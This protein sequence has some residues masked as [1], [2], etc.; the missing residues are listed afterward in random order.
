MTLSPVKS[1]LNK[2][3]AARAAGS[4]LWEQEGQ[5]AWTWPWRVPAAGTGVATSLPASSRPDPGDGGLSPTKDARTSL[6]H[7]AQQRQS[8]QVTRASPWTQPLDG[9]PGPWG[10]LPWEWG[11]APLFLQLLMSQGGVMVPAGTERGTPESQGVQGGRG[12]QEGRGEPSPGGDEGTVPPPPLHVLITL[13]GSPSAPPP[14]L[15]PSGLL[16][17]LWPHQVNGR[18]A[19][20]QSGGHCRG[21]MPPRL[22]LL[23]LWREI[24]VGGCPVEARCESGGRVGPWVPLAWQVGPLGQPTKD[25]CP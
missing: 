22:F 15:P 10:E 19:L 8:H 4:S 14:G 16:S 11:A 12:L 6:R 7:R 9:V 24:K 2:A 13:E 1:H 25:T 3:T 5:Q 23:D 20:G 18:R 17:A 21:P